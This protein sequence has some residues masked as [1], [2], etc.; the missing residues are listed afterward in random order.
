MVWCLINLSGEPGAAQSP[1][2]E[3]RIAKVDSD[4]TYSQ[5]SHLS[6]V[7]NR[8]QHLLKTVMHDRQAVTHGV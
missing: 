1:I 8:V 4:P 3:T 5:Y 2:I 6:E 7:V